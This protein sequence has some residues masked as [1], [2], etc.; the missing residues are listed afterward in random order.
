METVDLFDIAARLAVFAAAGDLP[1]C[2]AW[3]DDETPARQIV[4]RHLVECA[5]GPD[6]FFDSVAE[7]L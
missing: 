3:L 5:E 4:A 2:I 1:G 6:A 7:A